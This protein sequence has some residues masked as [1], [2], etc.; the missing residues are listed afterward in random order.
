[1]SALKADHGK[2]RFALH[3]MIFTCSAMTLAASAAHAQLYMV[4][5][6]D[7]ESRPGSPVVVTCL[8]GATLPEMGSSITL[9]MSVSGALAAPITYETPVIV[10]A[11]CVAEFEEAAEKNGWDYVIIPL[12][13]PVGP[14]E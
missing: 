7:L 4:T 13:A 8:D 3:R 11:S 2:R 12:D 1:M 9:E 5:L 10:G 6:A 14:T